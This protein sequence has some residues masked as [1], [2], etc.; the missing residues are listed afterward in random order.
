MDGHKLCREE[1]VV[2]KSDIL[3]APSVRAGAQVS[4]VKLARVYGRL[5]T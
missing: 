1:I 2:S 5:M 4:K 3:A